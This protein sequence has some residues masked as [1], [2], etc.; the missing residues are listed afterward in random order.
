MQQHR[1]APLSMAELL[2]KDEYHTD[3]LGEYQLR[4]VKTAVQAIKLLD[5]NDFQVTSE[6]MIEGLN[7]VVQNT[8]LKGRWQVLQESPKVICDTAHNREGLQFVMDQLGREKYSNLHFVLGVVNDKN[9][10]EYFISIT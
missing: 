2:I 5:Q 10:E 3:L 6:N 7:H 8:G 4:N 1:N 9:L